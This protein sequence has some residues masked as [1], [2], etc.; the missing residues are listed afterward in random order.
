MSAEPG[1]PRDQLHLVPRAEEGHAWESLGCKGR[2]E[3]K[4]KSAAAQVSTYSKTPLSANSK[5]LDPTQPL[6]HTQPISVK[7]QTSSFF[8]R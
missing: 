8:C 4:G 5:P 6:D 3:H 7:A 2:A 1:T